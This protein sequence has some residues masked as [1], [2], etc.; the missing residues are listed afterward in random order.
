MA[1]LNQ[2]EASMLAPF[3]FQECVVAFARWFLPE[4]LTW[5]PLCPQN[6]PRLLVRLRQF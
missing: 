1:L 5:G 4:A 2:R 6:V 3:L